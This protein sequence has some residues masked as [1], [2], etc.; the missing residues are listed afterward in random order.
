MVV[1]VYGNF[2]SPYDM[3]F[4]HSCLLILLLLQLLLLLLLLLLG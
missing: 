2:D 4:L 1:G 3:H